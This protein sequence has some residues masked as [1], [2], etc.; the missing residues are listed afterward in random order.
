MS[1]PHIC[2]QNDYEHC[3][4]QPKQASG[5]GG[6]PKLRFRGSSER[7]TRVEDEAA[8]RDPG[9]QKSSACCANWLRSVVAMTIPRR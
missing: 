9:S 1:L 4:R 3:N 5:N 7:W 2:R 8:N 6:L